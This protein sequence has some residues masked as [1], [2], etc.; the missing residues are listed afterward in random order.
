MTSDFTTDP[1]AH[2]AWF[3]D[4][5]REALYDPRPPVPHDEVEAH[6]AKRR[7]A[8]LKRAPLPSD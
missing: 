7:A 2:D 4:K 1:A 3:R 6:F 8:A 5:V